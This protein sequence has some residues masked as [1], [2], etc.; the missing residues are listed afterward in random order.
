VC[1]AIG[2]VVLFA[3][4]GMNIRSFIPLPELVAGKGVADVLI[5]LGSCADFSPSDA[6]GKDYFCPNPEET[7]LFRQDMGTILVREGREIV[8]DPAPGVKDQVLRLFILGPAL[9]AL[10]HQRGLL[11]L[12][13]S[14]VSVAGEVVAFMGRS[15]WGKSTTAAALYGRGHSI[16]AD[17]VTAV[18]VET[19]AGFPV[20][21]P[22]FPQLKLWPEAAAASVGDVPET[23]PRLDPRWDKRARRVGR[24]FPLSPLPLK[25]IYV[26][27]EGET[28]DIKPLLPQEALVELIKHSYCARLLQGT[29]PSSHFLQ[30][31][32]IVNSVTV[33]SLSRH[34]S[35]LEL[36]DLAR[37]IEED[38]AQSPEQDA[39]SAAHPS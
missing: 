11:V 35:L 5:R 9:A 21:F 14:A 25:R 27:D 4:Y 37:L 39:L 1:G 15:G 12:H 29:G 23:L 13:A 18:K 36:S 3:A 7:Y 34:R 20:V 22:G 31:S 26:L 30:C 6:A 33:S 28:H 38:L 8:V 32:R 16:V 2:G 24:E 19:D 17:D 10:L